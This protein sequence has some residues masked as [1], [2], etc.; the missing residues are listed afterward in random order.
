MADKPGK[1]AAALAALRG[2]GATDVRELEI[3]QGP[4][5]SVRLHGL[6]LAVY[7]LTRPGVIETFA[8]R[9]D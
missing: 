9:V 7:E 8:G 6:R 1:Y 2:A 5:A 3:P 4:C